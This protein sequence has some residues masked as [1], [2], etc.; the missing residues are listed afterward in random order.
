MASDITTEYNN[1][2][3]EL[4]N[5][6]QKISFKLGGFADKDKLKLVLDSKNP[7]NKG[8]VFVPFENYKI[9]LVS[10]S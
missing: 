1:F 5:L 10:S 2:V 4:S 6:K 3:T 8:N 7:S 9:D